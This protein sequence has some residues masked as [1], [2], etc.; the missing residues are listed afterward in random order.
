M[1]KLDINKKKKNVNSTGKFFS[2][3]I[4]K[5]NVNSTGKCGAQIERFN[6]VHPGQCPIRLKLYQLLAIVPVISHITIY[7]RLP[8]L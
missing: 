7:N 5:E 6:V 4:K 3:F 2:F 1:D 8:P